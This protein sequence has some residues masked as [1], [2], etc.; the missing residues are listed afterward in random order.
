MSYS[1]CVIHFNHLGLVSFTVGGILQNMYRRE[2]L[3]HFIR[4][5]QVLPK[6]FTKEKRL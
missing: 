2:N 1:G 3:T 6:L 4:S 5:H